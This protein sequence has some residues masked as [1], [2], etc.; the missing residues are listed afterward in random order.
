MHLKVAGPN[1]SYPL[2]GMSKKQT[3]VSH[4]TPESEIVAADLATRS[5]G[6]PALDLWEVLLN[7]KNVEL[8]F[9]EDNQA[10]ISIVETGKNPALRHMG[11]THQVDVKWLHESFRDA[12]FKLGYIQS[13]DQAADIYTKAFTSKEKWAVVTWL[14]GH[15]TRE[16]LVQPRPPN[17]E[18]AKKK[19]KVEE[20][21]TEPEGTP[22][23]P[24]RPS[25]LKETHKVYRTFRNAMSFKNLPGDLVSSG[26]VHRRVTRDA[27]TGEILDDLTMDGSTTRAELCCRIPNGPRHIAVEYWM[28]VEKYKD[29]STIAIR[30]RMCG[31]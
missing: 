23:V 18:K 9:Y 17:P 31:G 15:M 13:D 20:E 16:Q 14:I 28:P 4:S 12:H 8:Q 3:C 6:L 26:V 19:P 10:C 21:A 1:T 25:D 30:R 11:R 2:A 7:R 22:L 27:C 24:A 5:E 29:L